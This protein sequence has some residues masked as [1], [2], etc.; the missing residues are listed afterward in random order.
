M[1]EL[2]E[3][4]SGRLIG[5]KNWDRIVGF[6]FWAVLDSP[7][8]VWAACVAIYAINCVLVCMRPE[9]AMEFGFTKWNDVG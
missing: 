8:T 6:F 7:R 9:M 4:V 5:P 2:I 1:L 3:A